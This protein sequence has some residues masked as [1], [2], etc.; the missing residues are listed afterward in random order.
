MG[1][2]YSLS[3]PPAANLAIACFLVLARRIFGGTYS[4]RIEKTAGSQGRRLCLDRNNKQGSSFFAVVRNG[5][6]L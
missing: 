6:Y 5:E 4:N 3:A 2:F 1:V